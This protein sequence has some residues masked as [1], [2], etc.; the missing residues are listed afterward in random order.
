ME[1]ERDGAKGN[2]AEMTRDLQLSTVLLAA[3]MSTL[4][5]VPIQYQLLS[6]HSHVS[7]SEADV[8]GSDCCI[9]MSRI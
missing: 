8:N 6:S 1:I 7:V 2:L 4:P 3:S 5:Y 9:D